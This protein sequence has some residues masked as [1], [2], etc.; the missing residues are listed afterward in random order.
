MLVVP[1]VDSENGM[2]AA[3]AAE[4]PA[5]SPS[6]C[7]IR[8]YKVI[9]KDTVHLPEYFAGIATC[10]NPNCVTNHESCETHFDVVD[11]A[12]MTVRCLY[13]E[14]TFLGADL[15]IT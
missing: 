3:A 10:P 7:I 13:C 4:A 11:E 12:D 5:S 1:I 9:Q 6:V 2:P 14:R 15:T 8:D